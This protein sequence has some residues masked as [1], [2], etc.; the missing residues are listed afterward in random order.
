MSI[1]NESNLD[2]R[3]AIFSPALWLAGGLDEITKSA[4]TIDSHVNK[5]LN[6]ARIIRNELRGEQV[7]ILD[8]RIGC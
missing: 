8:E 1:T 7:G 5:V 2:P 4:Q 6:R 3:T